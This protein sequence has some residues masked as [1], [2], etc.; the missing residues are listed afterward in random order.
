MMFSKQFSESKISH[1]DIRIAITFL[2]LSKRMYLKERKRFAG[3]NTKKQANV[4]V[5]P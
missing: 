3:D 5:S 1:Q 4:T 2:V